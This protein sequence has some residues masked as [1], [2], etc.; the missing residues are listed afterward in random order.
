MEAFLELL[1]GVDKK[2]VNGEW[3]LFAE[4]EERP[5]PMTECA[6]QGVRWKDCQEVPLFRV[7]TRW[8]RM[9]NK[10]RL[11]WKQ[12]NM[13]T[14]LRVS[15]YSRSIRGTMLPLPS[16]PGVLEF[17]T[18]SRVAALA[19]RVATLAGKREE[20]FQNLLDFR[21]AVGHRDA[22]VPER[23]EV[24]E[25]M[26]ASRVMSNVNRF[27]KAAALRE[28]LATEKQ[29]TG[30]GAIKQLRGPR[31]GI[32]KVKAQLVELCKA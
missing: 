20:L 24:Y 29:K 18:S 17:A 9:V 23:A 30:T 22:L 31:G 5:H 19:F 13:M 12:R 25:A 11:S 16:C 3:K 15:K 28:K 2:D 6:Q 27:Q 8:T 14:L 32:T 26:T 7:A 21:A 1:G 4:Q 10:Q